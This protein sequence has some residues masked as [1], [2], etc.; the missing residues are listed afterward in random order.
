MARLGWLEYPTYRF[1]V[2]RSIHLSYRRSV[3]ANLSQS[4]ISVRVKQGRSGL[5]CRPSRRL[6]T[7]GLGRLVPEKAIQGGSFA[8][9]LQEAFSVATIHAQEGQQRIRIARSAYPTVGVSPSVSP[10]PVVPG[11]ESRWRP[12]R[13]SGRRDYRQ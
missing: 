2:C 8:T 9:A 10:C 4:N 13:H 6:G 7:S 3:Q 5:E 11:R 1:E 12:C